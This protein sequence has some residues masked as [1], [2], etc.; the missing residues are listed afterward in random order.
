MV[1]VRK[2]MSPEQASLL[3]NAKSLI[4]EI[5]A[6]QSG[7]VAEPELEEVEMQ[8]DEDEK[9]KRDEEYT[10]KS[11]GTTVLKQESEGSTASDDAEEIVEDLPEQT[12][13][14]VDEVAKA[15]VGM[16]QKA[17]INKSGSQT[18]LD[19]LSDNKT[20]MVA[21]N[22]LTKVVKSLAENQNDHDVA[23]SNIL[24]GLNVADTVRTEAKKTEAK[25]V[26]TSDLGNVLTEITKSLQSLKD[27]KSAEPEQ[28]NDRTQVRKSLKE[29]LP[30]VFQG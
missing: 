16:L 27:Q 4:E 8:L 12:E 20:F 9:K 2:Q 11:K 23:L 3:A 15:I 30:T 28:K 5:E 1:K 26:V 6:M 24:E 14:N 13:E 29:V 7:E 17:P 25:P 22:A 19:N 10:E 21:F 18:R